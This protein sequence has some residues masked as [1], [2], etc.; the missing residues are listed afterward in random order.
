[1]GCRTFTN[2]PPCGPKRGH[3]TPQ[4]RFGLEVHIDKICTALGVDPAAW[5]IENAVPEDS[6]TANWL[7]VSSTG[8]RRCIEAV[9]D[10]RGWNHWRATRGKLSQDPAKGEGGVA[11]GLGLACS[12][13]LCGAGL[14]IYWNQLPHTGVQLRLDRSGEV[15][16]FCG[17]TE[18]GQ[19]SDNVLVAIV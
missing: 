19:G 2:K 12:S 14:P 7:R 1:R 5:R 6:L 9:G 3:G 10:G 17:A 4:P 13:Y 16:A 8:L 15:V 18:I 11:R